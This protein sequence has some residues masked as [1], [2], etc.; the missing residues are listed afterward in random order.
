MTNLAD[1]IQE[2]ARRAKSAARTLTSLPTDAKN[3][4]LL[5]M[6]DSLDKRRS[7]IQ[8][9]NRKDLQAGQ[10]K[11]LSAAMLDRLE[12][13]DPVIQSMMDGLRE[14]ASLP[15]PVGEVEKMVKRPNGLLV[16]RMRVPLG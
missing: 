6:A 7:F 3:R 4:V 8:E 13:S 16:G 5:H 1:E 14:V 10:E 12:L 9:E 15:D 11:G 2:M